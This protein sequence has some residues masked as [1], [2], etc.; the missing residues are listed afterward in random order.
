ME[1]ASPHSSGI[2][3][4]VTKRWP[5]EK[6]PSRKTISGERSFVKF[7]IPRTRLAGIQGSQA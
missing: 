5:P 6:S 1:S 4:P 7:T 3:G 2:T